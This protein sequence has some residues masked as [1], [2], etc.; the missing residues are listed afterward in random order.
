MVRTSIIAVV[1]AAALLPGCATSPSDSTVE[2]TVTGVYLEVMPGVLLA[3]EVAHD[4]ESAPRWAEVRLDPVRTGRDRTFARIDTEVDIGVG[5]VVTVERG[6]ANTGPASFA[7]MI[8][9]GISAESV[10][11]PP[12]PPTRVA[13]VHSV[14]VRA[15]IDAH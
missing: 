3:P 11:R 6:N 14:R 1:T 9:P 7:N 10:H 8:A 5:D 12:A 4:A 2:G 15:E 13:L